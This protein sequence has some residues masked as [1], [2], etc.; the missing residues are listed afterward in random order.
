MP[1]IL[2]K[3]SW[4]LNKLYT[5]NFFESQLNVLTHNDVIHGNVLWDFEK[6]KYQLIDFE[7]AGFNVIGA[8][9][10]NLLMESLYKFDIKKWPDFE[11]DFKHFPSP[12]YVSELIKIYISYFKLNIYERAQEN[13]DNY[14]QKIPKKL[15]QSLELDFSESFYKEEVNILKNKQTNN[16]INVIQKTKVYQSVTLSQIDFIKRYGL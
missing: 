6:E 9:I 13:V 10:A 14:F 5:E 3:Y 16:Y 7:Y 1:C 15:I 12:E 2:E 11:R 4:I 8:D